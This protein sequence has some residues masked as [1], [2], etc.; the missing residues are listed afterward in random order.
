MERIQLE[1]L[2]ARIQVTRRVGAI[3]LAALAGTSLQVV[4]RR[5]MRGDVKG[6]IGGGGEIR[7]EF[8]LV[9]AL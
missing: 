8:L 7:L 1:K 6:G 2:N 9:Q 4:G 5:H 3:V